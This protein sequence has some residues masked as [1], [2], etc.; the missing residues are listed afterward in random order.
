MMGYRVRELLLGNWRNKGVALF[1]AVIIWFLAYKSET[2]SETIAVK[3]IP[4]AR[5]EG[6]VIIRQERLDAL[7]KAIPF[8]GTVLLTL[9]GPRRLIDKFRGE[10]SPREVRLPVEA[11]PDPSAERKGFLL[12]GPSFSFI[13]PGVQVASIV[14]ESIQITFDV[15]EEGEFSVEPVYLK[16][17]EGMEVET[18]KIEPAKVI[19][20]GP[21]SLLRGIRVIAEAWL[22]AADRFEDTLP[23]AVRFPETF[24]RGLVERTVRF[25][26]PSQVRFSARLRYKSDSF[27]AEGV[28]VRFLVPAARFPFRIQFDEESIKVRFQGPVQEVRRLRER[29][30]DP[31][32]VLAVAVPPPGAE[33]EQTIPFTEDSLLLY[34]FSERVRILQHPLRQAQNKGAWAYSLIPTPAA[35]KPSND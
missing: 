16:L 5:S 14:P 12:T 24:D 7:G 4:V 18:P 19:L 22:G 31:D 25:A 6:Q 33:A 26:G 10:A 29:V 15:S 13:P 17:P 20:R 1:F 30:K 21:R 23:L 28:R 3:V 2:Q 11:G 27:D 8:D 34:G 35:Q 9:S 32:F